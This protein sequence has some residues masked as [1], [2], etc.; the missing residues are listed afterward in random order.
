MADMFYNTGI[1]HIGDGLIDL[2]TDSIKIA[3]LTDAYTPSAAH[4]FYSDLT[5]EVAN[6]NGYTAGGKALTGVTWGFSS[7]YTVFD[8]ADVTWT[9]AT[10]TARYA[11]LYDASAAGSP[12]I[13]MLDLGSSFSSSGSDFTIQFDANGIFRF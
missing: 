1:K 10:I 2:D 7:P 6:G 4:E 9:G 12:L 8:A 13:M 3:L 11:A 5:G